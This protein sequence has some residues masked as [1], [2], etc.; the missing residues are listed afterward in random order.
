MTPFEFSNLLSSTFNLKEGKDIT[1]RNEVISQGEYQIVQFHP[2][3]SYEDFVR[4]IVAETDD[5]GNI[6]YKV[7]NKVL[8]KFAKKAQ[9]NPNGKYV[10]DIR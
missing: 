4:G 7:E 8:A 6:S 1:E 5:N 10:F 9:D 3:Y 2:A